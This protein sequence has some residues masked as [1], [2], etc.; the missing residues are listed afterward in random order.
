[1]TDFARIGAL[2][3]MVALLAACGGDTTQVAGVGTEGTGFASGTIS[4]FGSII[5]DGDRFDDTGAVFEI[6]DD[7]RLP[8]RPVSGARLGER[9]EATLRSA[10]AVERA[11]IEPALIGPASNVDIA[12]LTVR[13]AGQTVRVNIDPN[14]GP[15]T[16]LDLPTFG[17][18]LFGGNVQVHG[19]PVFDAATG[20]YRIDAS[21]IDK[22]TALPANLVR[23]SGVVSALTTTSF[24]L[25]DLTV[26]L[27]GSLTVL[28]TGRPLADGLFVTVWGSSLSGSAPT[29]TLDAVAVRIRAM[30]ST[31]AGAAPTSVAGVISRFDTGA[32]TFDLAGVTVDARNASIVPAGQGLT[33]ADDQY[34][35][36]RGSINASGTLVAQQV[37]VRRKLQN[38]AEI[39]LRG[40]IT[41]YT[42]DGSFRVRGTLVD[43]S[44]VSSRPR[45]PTTLRNDLR[46]EIVGGVRPNRQDIVT[47]ERLSCDN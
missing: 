8:P 34:V 17:S 7:P 16:L 5:L 30:P 18:M 24:R 33:L 2:S 31:P 1:M 23:T 11:R 15:V 27:P 3:L 22:L 4:G 44:D 26:R 43:A 42:S 20:R 10:N 46:V 41:D 12:G 39:E 6:E 47:A 40:T 21:R 25:G 35:V 32:L 14:R 19:M 36:A 13:V 28:P 37:R 38:E 9:V 29:Q 45:C